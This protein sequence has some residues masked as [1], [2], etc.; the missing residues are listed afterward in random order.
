[1]SSE[2]RAGYVS[3]LTRGY[4]VGSMSYL[5]WDPGG[6]LFMTYA[7]TNL[8]HFPAPHWICLL[9][10]PLKLDTIPSRYTVLY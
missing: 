9:K 2:S 3:C 8:V 1:M 4:E 5:L 6:K 7:S 10:H